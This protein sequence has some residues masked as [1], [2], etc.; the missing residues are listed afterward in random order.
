ML[1]EEQ[2]RKK[3]LK[4]L[5]VTSEFINNPLSIEE[6]SQITGISSSSVQRYLNDK[7]IIEL[8]GKETYDEIKHLLK[9]RKMQAVSKGGFV[10][11][12]N[13]EPVRDENGKFIGNKKSIN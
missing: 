1:S 2:K 5:K 12:R 7:R 10:S 3:D 4:I 13:N 9:I 11:T 8:L 6:I